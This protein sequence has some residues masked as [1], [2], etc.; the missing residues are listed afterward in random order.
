MLEFETAPSGHT[1][2]AAI[3][4]H[5]NA[6]GPRAKIELTT[7]WDAPVLVEIEHD[8]LCALALQPGGQVYLHPREEQV[9]VY[10]T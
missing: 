3:V 7:D 10:Q 9:F 2:F 5:I 6:A 8:R 4:Q 1:S